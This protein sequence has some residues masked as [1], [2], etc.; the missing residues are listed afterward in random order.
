MQEFVSDD[1]P[2]FRQCA[3]LC[4]IA[5]GPNKSL[6]PKNLNLSPENLT[7][8]TSWKVSA[9]F[10][11]C[12]DLQV[13]N[14]LNFLKTEGYFRKE[15]CFHYPLNVNRVPETLLLQWLETFLPTLWTF[16][17]GSTW[18]LSVSLPPQ[19]GLLAASSSSLFYLSTLSLRAMAEMPEVFFALNF[20]IVVWQPVA[21]YFHG[22]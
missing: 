21:V 5:I 15:H 20:P 1:V 11:L 19:S 16:W 4:R 18:V 17:I 10:I 13:W 7:S 14:S 6:S 9:S 3:D 8:P 12:C 2:G 22:H